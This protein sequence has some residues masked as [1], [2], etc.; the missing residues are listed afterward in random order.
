MWDTGFDLK[1]GDE[2]G[3]FVEEGQVRSVADV[4]PSFQEAIAKRS[5]TRGTYFRNR[6]FTGLIRLSGEKAVTSSCVHT[7]EGGIRMEALG[8]FCHLS[9]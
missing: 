9:W 7:P 6:R 8:R 4:L 3:G 2:F 5:P 1:L